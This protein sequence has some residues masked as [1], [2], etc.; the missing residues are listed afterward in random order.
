MIDLIKL[1]NIIKNHTI[2]LKE[3]DVLNFLKIKHRWPFRYLGGQPSV[4]IIAEDGSS[5]S[6]VF[7]QLDSYLD[8]DK[9]KHFYDLGFTTII[10]NTFDLND[11]LRN[12]NKKLTDETGLRLN[13]NMY[14]SKPGKLPSFPY[15][16]HKYDVIV[17]QIYGSSEWRLGDKHFTLTSENTC[18]IPKN[19][20]H[21]V[22]S[23]NENKLSLTINIE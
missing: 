14:F 4:E 12:L 18:I 8:Y 21:Q 15:H 9:W 5:V 2:N 10:S 1:E 22:L 7:F 19:T 16:D 3:E 11:E 17:K 23:K 20:S 6:T 13:C